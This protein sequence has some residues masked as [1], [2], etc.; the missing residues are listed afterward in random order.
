MATLVALEEPG[1]PGCRLT[2]R[3]VA[4]LWIC[5]GE[6]REPKSLCVPTYP[7]GAIWDDLGNVPERLRRET[8]Q[9]FEIY[10]DIDNE[11]TSP[12]RVHARRP[13]CTS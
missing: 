5:S 7:D 2:P 1:V 3:P 9:F 8:G 11:E 10:K 13:S 12:P 4:V 6:R